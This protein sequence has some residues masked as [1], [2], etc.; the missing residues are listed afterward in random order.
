MAT[1]AV[2]PTS[3]SEATTSSSAPAAHSGDKVSLST[4]FSSMGE[5]RKREPKLYKFMMQGIAMNMI[6]QM[7][8]QESQL[9]RIMKEGQRESNTG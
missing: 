1:E 2:T 9:E 7:Q 8:R 3:G 6:S 5:L 4:K